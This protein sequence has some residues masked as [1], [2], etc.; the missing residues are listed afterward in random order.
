M[1][2]NEVTL[3]MEYCEDG[4]L[5]HRLKAAFDQKKKI[6]EERILRWFTMICMGLRDI[7]SHQVYC[8]ATCHSDTSQMMHRDLKPGNVFLS[9]WDV[10]KL[11]DFGLGALAP[12]KP[13]EFVADKERDIAGTVARLFVTERPRRHSWF[14]VS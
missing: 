8:E 3:V 5:Y 7:H 13:T 2:K 14:H 6:P 12:R 1:E 11:G 10:V 9:R 4:D